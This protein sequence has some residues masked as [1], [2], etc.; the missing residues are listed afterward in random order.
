M[1]GW[2]GNRRDRNKEAPHTIDWGGVLKAAHTIDW[3]CARV[4]GCG[5]CV[6]VGE[7]GMPISSVSKMAQNNLLDSKTPASEIMVRHCDGIQHSQRACALLV[8][9]CCCCGGGGG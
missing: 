5:V 8:R 3:G 9:Y 6:R 7:G 1:I 4:E 2:L